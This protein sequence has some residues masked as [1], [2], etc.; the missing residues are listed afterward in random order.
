MPM[1]LNDIN[2]ELQRELQLANNRLAIAIEGLTAIIENADTLNIA[3]K[4]LEEI[5]AM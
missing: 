1:Q 3:H 4:T 5:E 2:F